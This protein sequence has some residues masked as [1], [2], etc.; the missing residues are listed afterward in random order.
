MKIPGGRADS[1]LDSRLQVVTIRGSDRR[2]EKARRDPEMLFDKFTV[3]NNRR[4]N[5]GWGGTD[6][7][8]SSPLMNETSR[9]I[10]LKPD[11]SVGEV[12][13]EPIEASGRMSRRPFQGSAGSSVRC[14]DN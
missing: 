11:R 10:W 3:C 4:E 14:N 8:G 13:D 2:A 9:P 1:G 7:S 12:C 6:S 5:V